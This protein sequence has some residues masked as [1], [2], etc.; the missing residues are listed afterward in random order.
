MARTLQVGIVGYGIAGIAAAIQLRRLGHSITHFDRN[1]PPVAVGAGML[2]HPPALRQLQQLGVLEAALACGATVRRISAQSVRGRPIMDFG[3]ADLA[4]G[5]FGLGIQRKALHRLLSNAD[6]GRDRVRG[7]CK[8]ASLDAERGY[9]FD[10]LG[11]RHGPYELIVIADG[12]HSLL[13][14][15]MRAAVRYERNPDSAALVGL[16]DD[17]DS[18]AADHLVQ[19]FD[20][21]RHL[22]VWPVGR[23]F[24]ADPQKCAIAMNVSRAEAAAFRDSGVWRDWVSRLCPDIGRR[25]NDC[26]DDSSLHI[27]TYHDVE[28]RHWAVGRAVVIGDAAHSMSPQ[29][30]NGAQLAMEDAAALTTAVDRHDDLFGALHSY[31]CA[32]KRQL[33]RYHLASRWL[34]PLFQS[35]SRTM[36]MLRDHVFANTMQLPSAKRFAHALLSY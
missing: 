17:P 8:I 26:V 11:I 4:A 5:H 29:L 16:L 27:F 10:D 19:Y 20:V 35:N 34:T 3:Y 12:A 15:R 24:P 36:A 30:G 33:R 1:D 25:V 6:A 23:E 2:L 7:G 32:R 18:P 9:L 31:G 13:R 28:L 21:G 22:S 14:R